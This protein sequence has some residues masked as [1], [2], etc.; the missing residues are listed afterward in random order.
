[1]VALVESG[2]L[3]Y[4]IGCV[5]VIYLNYPGL[6]LFIFTYLIRFNALDIAVLYERVGRAAAGSR[7]VLNQ[8]EGLSY[9]GT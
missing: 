9:K 8:V 1:M 7:G 3:C 2:L 6:I 5:V 4:R